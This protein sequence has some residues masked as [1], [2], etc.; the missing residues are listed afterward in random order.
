[1]QRRLWILMCSVLC[2]CLFFYTMAAQADVVPPLVVTV[3]IIHQDPGELKAQVA[4]VVPKLGNN[5]EAKVVLKL[6]PSGILRVGDGTERTIEPIAPGRT[7][8]F[9]VFLP[10]SGYGEGSLEAR[11]QS[12]N[13]KG[14][15][16]WGRAESLFVLET[17]EDRL[18]DRGSLFDLKCEKL[19]RDLVRGKLTRKEYDEEFKNLTHGVELKFERE[20]KGLPPRKAS[21]TPQIQGKIAST[22][23]SGR[24]T[25]TPRIGH[26][27][28]D[29]FATPDHA[30]PIRRARVRFF[31]QNGTTQTEL[32]SSPAVVIT[33]EDGNYSAS[34]SGQRG[35]TSAVQLVV[36][37][38]A[39][40]AGA[41]AGPRNQ[42]AMIYSRD[43]NPQAVTA[44]STVVD[45]PVD[46]TDLQ[47]L[48]IFSILDGVLTAYDYVAGGAGAPPSQIFIEFPGTNAN[49]SFFFNSPDDH[50]NIGQGH[51]FDWDVYTH[52]YGHYVQKIN[53][54]TQNPGGCHFINGNNTGFNQASPGCIP[55][56]NRTLTKQQAISLAWGEGWPTFFGTILQI[57]SGAGAK[58]IFAVADT[59]YTDTANGFSY[60]L[61]GNADYVTA[62]GEDNE[63]SVQRILW[64]FAD[65]AQDGHDEVT[66]GNAALQEITA[67]SS[68]VTLDAFR[69]RF[70]GRVPGSPASYGTGS[71]EQNRA[72]QG[73]IYFDLNVG[74][75]PMAPMDN[76]D[77]DPGHPP[78]FRWESKGAGPSPSYRFNRFNVLFFTDDYSHLIF[79]SPDVTTMGNAATAEWTPTQAEW[80]TI[81]GGAAAAPS[82]LVK[83]V[84]QGANDSL[85]PATGPYRGL[86]RT[87][88][89]LDI[90]FVIDDT[91]SMTEEIGGVRSALSNEIATIRSLGLA[92]NPLIQVITFKDEVTHRIV[93]RD[94]DAIQTIVDG[95]VADGGGDCPESS[96]EALLDA[97]KNLGP[98]KVLL[99]ATDAS[100]H[101]GFDLNG[102]KLAVHN[103]GIT[104]T[105]IVSGD[106]SDP[107]G[108]LVA[109]AGV[110]TSNAN[111]DSHYTP[112]LARPARPDVY[113]DVTCPD[114]PADTS[115]G[116][117][118]SPNALA[119]VGDASLPQP[120]AVVAYQDIALASPRGNFLFLPGVNT[121]DS[122]PFENAATNAA[123]SAT[124][125]T[126]ITVLP[127]DLPQGATLD[128]E[129]HAGG[130]NF[131]SGT[132]AS[133]GNGV[134]V[135]S[136][137]A[138][139]P[140]TLRLNVTVSPAA[141]VGFRDVRVTTPLGGGVTETTGGSHQVRIVPNA[142]QPAL[143]SVQPRLL[144][145][146]TPVDL[147]I[148]GV[149]TGFTAPVT[150]AVNG[151][152]VESVT[153]LSPTS[154]R[155]RV[156][157]P[158]TADLGFRALTVTS[159]A[160]ELILPQALS[161]VE[162]LSPGGGIPLIAL[163]SPSNGTRG[164]TVTVQITGLNTH[165]VAGVTTAQVSGTGV[166]VLSTMVTSPTQASVQLLI[167]P[168]AILGYRDITLG[169]GGETAVQLSGF[170]IEAGVPGTVAVPTLGELGLLLLALGLATV[171]LVSLRRQRRA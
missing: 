68:V 51:A 52:E 152:T 144:A 109:G 45:L 95:L 15:Q 131:Q 70:D 122:L 84:V 69:T 82:A 99:F 22:T 9:N 170:L 88:G 41:K 114:C 104:L 156:A 43:S 148:S 30:Q 102:I 139:S 83:W 87:L 105:E 138:L 124:L 108:F 63:L 38:E 21:P 101:A 24:A 158:N 61:E 32:T 157:V 19:K 166:S 2:G 171:G 130:T 13:A 167:Q 162:E 20:M 85:A 142:G 169:T 14:K 35:D 98:G 73:A 159:G 26:P 121:G 58:G 17:P 3:K 128:V 96:A 141:A 55:P 163:V 154:L 116:P 56:V 65:Q 125:P 44:V 150:A 40:N 155:V 107:G 93:S 16:L 75:A 103:R 112:R 120:S 160:I 78:T 60:D 64:D 18:F 46:S 39:E 72:K 94:L 127:T 110:S 59:R 31:D 89:A 76:A 137:Q 34:I 111:H 37:L 97:A 33:D 57:E 27:A 151:I 28:G 115:V 6:T 132:T 49:G 135:N 7:Y 5:S 23:V 81:T 140:N 71:A 165:F 123:L 10:I 80:D 36:R 100:P 47:N 133:L 129:V 134:V 79:S 153:V 1:M 149:N 86:A 62:T 11:A 146:G 4:V 147:M 136:T 118:L 8:L 92:R 25:Y 161:I 90:A 117:A 29:V 145:R 66:Y 67:D 106:C 12:F 77:I 42:R 168:D 113:R 91:G 119:L 126:V 53:N 74:P 143:V 164:S 54:T 50:L 48:Q